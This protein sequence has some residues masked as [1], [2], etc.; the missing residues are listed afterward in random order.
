MEPPRALAADETSSSQG[1]AL[2]VLLLTLVAALGGLLFGYDTAVISG[3]IGFLTKRFS[4]N[5]VMQGWAA[6][7]V[8]VGCMIGASVAGF[9]S[10]RFGRKKAMVLAAVLFTVSAVGAAIPRNVTEFVIARMLGGVGIGIASMLSPLYISEIAP[11]RSRGRLVSVNQFA[12]IFGMLVVYFVNAKVASLGSEA[13]NVAVGWR[14]MFASGILPALLF[15]VLLAAVPESPRWLAKRGRSSE[16]ERVLARIGGADHARR[17]IADIQ[18]ALT[19]KREESL[20]QLFEPVMRLPLLI[21]IGL[22]ILQQ[23]TGINIVLYYAP[24]IFRSAGSLTHKAMNDTV[25]VG[26]VNLAFTIVAIGIV[27]RLGRKP[28]LLIAS[29]GMGVSLAL[30][31]WAFVFHL[32]Q[33]PLVLL[34]VLTYVA[35]FA[36]AMGPV[37]WV[38]IA[39]IFPTR[40]RGRAMSVA[41]VCL[42]LS[43]FAVTQLFPI[44]LERLEGKV[45]FLYAVICAAAFVFVA[46]VVPETKGKSLEEIERQWFKSAESPRQTDG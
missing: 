11:A 28:L 33:G 46:L 43:C 38:V 10:D 24:E 42:W 45:F 25:I 34:F 18:D 2:Y 5:A 15:L 40:I 35:S 23:I 3:A 12:I 17:E 1:S 21:G 44:M 6:G 31:G 22:A 8:L 29:A 19:H 41:T 14:W 20:A 16:A 9:V 13:W 39:E 32:F 7:S 36:L 30:L 27:D 37:V 26:A 4:L